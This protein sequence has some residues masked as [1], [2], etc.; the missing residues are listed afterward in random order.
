MVFY[1]GSRENSR[2]DTQVVS[3]FKA[4]VFIFIV[5]L[6]LT[7]GDSMYCAAIY[8][9]ILTFDELRLWKLA[10]TRTVLRKTKRYAMSCYAKEPLFKGNRNFF[11]NFTFHQFIN[12]EAAYRNHTSFLKCTFMVFTNI[13]FN[14]FNNF[15]FKLI[16]TLPVLANTVKYFDPYTAPLSKCNMMQEF[17]LFRTFTDFWST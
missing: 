6:W 16:P 10:K 15:F 11:Q 7:N 9:Y 2:T 14:N 3:Y 1:T 5:C 13:F 17:L 4:I 8:I 12:Q